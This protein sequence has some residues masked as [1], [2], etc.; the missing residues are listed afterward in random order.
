MYRASLKRSVEIYERTR[1]DI[2]ANQAD[3]QKVWEVFAV[4]T[5]MCIFCLQFGFIGLVAEEWKD[6][7]STVDP[8]DIQYLDFVE[9][10]RERAKELREEVR[11][12]FRS[13]LFIPKVAGRFSL[14]H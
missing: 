3:K 7:L 9:E 5:C 6:T 11:L 13:K 14:Q 4:L 10:G 8:D 1:V 2:V 12:Q